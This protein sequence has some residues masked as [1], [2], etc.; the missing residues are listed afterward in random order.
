MVGNTGNDQIIAVKRVIVKIW[1]EIFLEFLR[2]LFLF[3][4][5]LY[6]TFG[7]RISYTF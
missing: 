5:P 1:S 2:K 3:I 4:L 6:E 7:K